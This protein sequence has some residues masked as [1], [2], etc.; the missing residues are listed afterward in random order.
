MTP[1]EQMQN[2]EMTRVELQLALREHAPQNAQWWAY[3]V[4]HHWFMLR[5]Y[6]PQTHIMIAMFGCDHIAGPTDWV[7][8]SLTIELAHTI[9]FDLKTNRWVISDLTVGFSAEGA[10]LYWGKDVGMWEYSGWFSSQAVPSG[11]NFDTRDDPEFKKCAP[12]DSANS[13]RLVHPEQA[14][15]FAKQVIDIAPETEP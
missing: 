13:P 10:Q 6:R 4:S 3:S 7:N 15:Q 5:L 14:S 9:Q 2:P 1:V 11:P 8:P 12:H